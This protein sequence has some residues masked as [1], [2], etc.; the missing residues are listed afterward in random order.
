M[1]PEPYIRP[2]KVAFPRPSDDCPK[3]GVKFSPIWKRYL[4]A[5]VFVLLCG[6]LMG[7]IRNDELVERIS[8]SAVEQAR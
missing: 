8:P 4:L 2:D 1:I 5:F 3:K 7:H 6:F